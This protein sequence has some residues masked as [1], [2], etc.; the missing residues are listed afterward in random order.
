MEG[1]RGRCCGGTKKR[2]CRVCCACGKEEMQGGGGRGRAVL[3]AW[4]RGQRGGAVG[5]VGG[6]TYTKIKGQTDGGLYRPT[7]S[8]CHRPL[9]ACLGGRSKIR[10][11][12]SPVG[13]C[14]VQ[15][16][17]TTSPRPRSRQENEKGHTRVF[18]TFFLCIG[19]IA[20][21]CSSLSFW[22]RRLNPRANGANGR[23]PGVV[24]A[25]PSLVGWA[26]A[27]WGHIRIWNLALAAHTWSPL[28]GRRVGVAS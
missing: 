6:C 21:F 14:G 22:L 18:H 12:T 7:S 9:A 3:L 20:L 19:S 15:G 4:R 27:S 13:W 5:L 24:F 25:Q 11:A 1:A 2:P 26:N 28:E 8:D 10:S 23:G 17:P 16:Q